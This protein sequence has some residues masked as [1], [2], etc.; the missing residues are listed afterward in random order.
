MGTRISSQRH[1]DA[2][3]VATKSAA[4]DYSIVVSPTFSVAGHEYEVVLD[5]HHSLAAALA[6]GVEPVAA[7]ATATVHDAVALLDRGE[8]EAFLAAVHMG[9]DYYDVA[10]GKLVF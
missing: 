6:D 2:D 3:V 9:D 7:V 8:V 10:T 1:I 5:G 4:G